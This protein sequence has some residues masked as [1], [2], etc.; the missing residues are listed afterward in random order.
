MSRV[1]ATKDRES[2][3]V[4]SLFWFQ[5]VFFFHWFNYCWNGKTPVKLAYLDLNVQ[6]Y[7]V[8]ALSGPVLLVE[9]TCSGPSKDLDALNNLADKNDLLDAR[10]RLVE[11]QLHKAICHLC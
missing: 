11:R 8:K 3:S 2:V 7:Q 4:I 1:A 9:P 5:L 6:A 10:F